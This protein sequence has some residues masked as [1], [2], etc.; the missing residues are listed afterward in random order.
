MKCRACGIQMGHYLGSETGKKVYEF[1]RCPK[2]WSESKHFWFHFEEE[3]I[4]RKGVIEQSVL[5]VHND[6]KR[7]KKAHKRR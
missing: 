3:E 5:R 6:T 4:K 2:C 7:R 1:W